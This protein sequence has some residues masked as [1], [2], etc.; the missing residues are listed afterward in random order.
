VRA[1]PGGVGEGGR[2]AGS[3]REPRVLHHQGDR[4]AR[5]QKD[6]LARA[7]PKLPARGRSAALACLPSP[8]PRVG[9]ADPRRA[10]EGGS[11]HDDHKE[12]K[13]ARGRRVGGQAHRVRLQQPVPRPRRAVPAQVGDQD[14]LQDA[15]ADAHAHAG[16]RRACQDLL[17]C[18]V[19]HGAQRVGHAA[20]GQEGRRI[21]KTA[22]D[23]HAARVL[24]R[25]RRPA[26]AAAPAQAPHRRRAHSRIWDV[27]VR[28]PTSGPAR[29]ER[30]RAQRARRPRRP[31]FG[32]FLPQS[33]EYS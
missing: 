18:G 10:R 30:T 20:L 16:P 28:S 7:V 9:D 17:P 33:P 25:V 6:A 27:P 19:A 23:A 24:P 11:V 21:P 26:A 12:K 13:K 3:A 29:Q 22:Q 14:Q 8:G 15:K 4:A 2:Q 5:A 32:A 31:S 1:R